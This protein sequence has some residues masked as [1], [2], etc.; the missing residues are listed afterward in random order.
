N[1]TR[2]P[3]EVIRLKVTEY[4]FFAAGHSHGWLSPYCGIAL[5]YNK[6]CGSKIVAVKFK[7]SMEKE[8]AYEQP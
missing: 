4:L 3:F 2:H 8:S 1:L 5:S 7:P 6:M